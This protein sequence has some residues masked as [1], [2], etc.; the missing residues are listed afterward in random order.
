MKS[1]QR[2]ELQQNSLARW[3]EDTVEWCKLNAPLLV[4]IVLGVAVVV[5]GYSYF[6]NQSETAA[7][8]E[9]SQ[10]FAALQRDDS[11][12]LQSLGKRYSG[13]TTGQLANLY[14]ADTELAAGVELMSTDRDQAEVKLNEAK[15]HY[16]DVRQTASDALVLQRAVFGLAR[17][18]ETMGLLPEAIK[19]YDT[20]VK[21]FPQ[22][23]FTE[24]AKRKVEFLQ[25]PQ[26]QA[27]ADWYQK[28][29]PLPPASTIGT[30]MP[31]FGDLDKLPP[32]EKSFPAGPK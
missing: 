11:V 29:K 7:I 16:A 9:W 20:L 30:G 1:E 10:L 18:Y 12:K 31:N 32:D 23:V 22:G 17:Y 4:G 14:L 27:F 24:I 6:R 2:H 8:D 5:G 3:L 19:A 26:T 28:H 21:D 13:Q 25:F 15:N